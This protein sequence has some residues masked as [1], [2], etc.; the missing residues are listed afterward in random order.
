MN[1][2]SALKELSQYYDLTTEMMTPGGH[3]TTIIE[4]WAE[5]SEAAENGYT[6]PN[7]YYVSTIDGI[8]YRTARGSDG[9]IAY[10]LK[11]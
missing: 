2:L 9:G 8:H 6:D 3:E 11:K 5:E 4:A 7:D 10:A 1:I